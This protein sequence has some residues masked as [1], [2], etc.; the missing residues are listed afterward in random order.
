MKDS[1]TYIKIQTINTLA[2]LFG[3][4]AENSLHLRI[5]TFHNIGY[6]D[7]T[8][9]LNKQQFTD[10]L[11]IL[12]DNG[13]HTL[14]AHDLVDS[15]PAI[16]DQD[17]NVMLTFDDGYASHKDDVAELLTRYK[18]TATFFVLS[19]YVNKQ[20]STAKFAGHS[21]LFLSSEDLKQMHAAGFEI[22]S[23]THTHPL[24]GLIS[25]D[26]FIHEISLSKQILEDAIESCVTTF[27]FPYGRQKAYTSSNLNAL[28][29]AGYL[30]AFTQSGKKITPK[31]SLLTLPRINID[32]FDTNHTFQ[33]KLLGNY[34]LV[35]QLRN[36]AK[37]S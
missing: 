34:E 19:S 24:C 9:T 11:S 35:F 7:S 2:T 5:L 29:K 21:N 8:H 15:W 12:A 26:Q 13:Y 14:R 33:R 3:W 22:G 18:M 17:H 6:D 37:Q 4:I 23:H 10:F 28:I 31:S 27:S 36:Y 30:A 32:R 20:R 16:L 25:D 1:S